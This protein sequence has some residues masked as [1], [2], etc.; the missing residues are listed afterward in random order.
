MT[1]P[2]FPTV[3]DSTIMAAFRSCPR[4]AE[5]EFIQHWKPQTPSVHLHAGA[6]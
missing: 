6:A 5:L 4:K 1:R 3:L 2:P